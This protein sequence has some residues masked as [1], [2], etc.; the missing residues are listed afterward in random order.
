MTNQ[1]EPRANKDVVNK[2]LRHINH[3]GGEYADW[4]VGIEDAGSDRNQDEKCLAR[5]HL[6]SEAEAKLTMSRLLEL[7][8]QADDEY[9]AEPTILF[10]YTR[11]QAA[12]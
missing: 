4:Y 11:R 7:G 12:E 8:L 6:A 1:H 5:H 10:V 3:H 9:G 2:A